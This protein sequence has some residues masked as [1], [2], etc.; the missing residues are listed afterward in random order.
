MTTSLP[1]LK[2]AGSPLAKVVAIL[3]VIGFLFY[4]L[5]LLGDVVT[6]LIISAVLKFLL[7][8]VVKLMEQHFEISRGFAVG[9]VLAMFSIM[10]FVT[11]YYGVPMLFSFGKSLYDQMSMFPLEVKLDAVLSDLA[12]TFRIIDERKL[13]ERAHGLMAAEGNSLKGIIGYIPG[14]IG[15]LVIVPFVLYFFLAEGDRGF[16]KAIEMVPNRYFEMTLN[17]VEII[18]NKLAGY[19]RGLLLESLSVGIMMAIGCS[20]IGIR[21]AILIGLVAGCCNFIPYFGVIIGT[22]AALF[23]SLLQFGD[24]HLLLAILAVIAI[25]QLTDDLF[26]RPLL[27]GRAMDIH[28]I[29]VG[30][31]LLLGR[32]MLGMIGMFFA[33]PV[34][35]IVTVIGKE[36]YRGFTRYRITREV[37]LPQR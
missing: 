24:F 5:T 11:L 4:L 36:C 33:I 19:F 21:H 14:M 6:I 30:I 1:K 31:V 23:V 26:L 3:L 32:G 20:V 9:I 28:P 17:I 25:V 10:L 13:L 37:S 18:S 12:R 34:Y 29:T 16:K 35:I 8:P 7:W 15:N 22:L 2:K 27:F